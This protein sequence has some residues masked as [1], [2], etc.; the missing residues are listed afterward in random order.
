M[1]H[2]AGNDIMLDIAGSFQQESQG[3]FKKTD[4]S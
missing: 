3:S 4:P 2:L 1:M